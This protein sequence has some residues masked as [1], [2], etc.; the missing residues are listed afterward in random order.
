MPP[1][2]PDPAFPD[3]MQTDWPEA[4]ATVLTCKYDFGAGRAL[5]GIPTSRHFRI[6]YNYFADGELHNGELSA[7]KPIPQGS[8]FPIRYNPNAPHDH[9]HAHGAKTPPNPR[10]AMLAIGLAGS[11][12]LSLL[13]FAVMRGCR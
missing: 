2:K 4:L 6:S 8:L 3:D 12:V 5:I 1:P 7:A 9:S 10:G 13:W 11:L